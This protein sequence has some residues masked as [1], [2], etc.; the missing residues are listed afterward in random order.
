MVGEGFRGFIE[1]GGLSETLS[2]GA[3]FFIWLSWPTCDG[4]S[5][6]PQAQP[7]QTRRKKKEKKGRDP[8]KEPRA[9]PRERSYDYIKRRY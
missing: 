2:A 8:N 3:S 1:T 7:L 5:P 9:A 4:W 6:G